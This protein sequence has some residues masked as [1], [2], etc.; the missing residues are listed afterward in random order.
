VAVDSIK[1]FGDAAYAEGTKFFS[2]V[3]MQECGNILGRNNI[4]HDY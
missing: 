1:S 2:V 3:I 4:L